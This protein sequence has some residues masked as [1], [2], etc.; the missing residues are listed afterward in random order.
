MKSNRL[1]S[2]AL[3]CGLILGQLASCGDESVSPE[4]T[5][6]AASGGETTQAAEPAYEFSTA[7]SG[8]TFSILNAGDVYNMRAEIDREESTG[9][10]LNDAMYERCR[11]FE[12]RTGVLIEEHCEHVDTDLANYAM[13]TILSGE[14]LYD[15]IY[16]PARDLYKFTSE[17][18]LYNLLDYDAFKFDEPWWL[19]SYNE[20]NSI[21][22]E[23]YAAAGY[24]QLMIVDS[25]WC[26]FFNETMMTDLGLDMP[27][28]LVREGNWTLDR[29]NE[30]ISAGAN[31]NGDD[32]F[33]NDDENGTCI[34][35]LANYQSDKFLVG[36]DEFI[37]E[38]N[39]GKLEITAGSDRFYSL[40]DKM[41]T[42]FSESDGHAILHFPAW[43][44]TDDTPNSAVGLFEHSRALFLTAELSKT[45]RQRDKSYSYG[46]VPFPKYDE[47]QESYHATS[48]Y[49]T[50]CYSIPVTC[51]DPERSAI[52]G[53]ALTYLSYEMV[54][55]V[56][57]N[58]T[59]EQKGLRNEDSI[60]MLDIIIKSAAPDLVLSYNIGS[61]MRTEVLNAITEK[62]GNF[63]SI[64]ASYESQ[65]KTDLDKVNNNQ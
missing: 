16:M 42:I 39:G 60:E 8:S 43:P 10:S 15:T 30:Y 64:Y 7:Y 25:I 11:T 36:A 63:A 53:D 21:G 56:Y 57:R 50:P 13:Q 23:L 59:L 1:I 26:L 65:M 24:S 41:S 40:L 2:L 31:L 32:S 33:S 55:P 54:W 3:L 14:D 29:L 46:I 48:F 9:E 19:K 28:D 35:G 17:G 45:S 62:T 20:A 58:T 51:A 18:M 52:L 61:E 6:D 22:G 34:Y 37:V 4:N 12:D 44:A 47:S 27:Y 49:G 38:E 5:T